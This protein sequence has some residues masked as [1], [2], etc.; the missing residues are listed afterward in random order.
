MDKWDRIDMGY[1]TDWPDGEYL[2]S[3][4][5]YDNHNDAIKF[6]RTVYI[7]DGI[8]TRPE[9]KYTFT[10]LS[11]FEVNKVLKKVEP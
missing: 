5:I 10:Q 2:V 7:K 9:W 4:I 1:K 3:H 6:S 8:V 11:F